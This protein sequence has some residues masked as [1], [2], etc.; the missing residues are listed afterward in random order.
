MYGS[1]SMDH[2]KS[3]I[4]GWAQAEV[5]NGQNYY[6]HGCKMFQH[7]AEIAIFVRWAMTDEWPWWMGKWTSEG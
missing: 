4:S 7:N 5:A 6:N 2:S 3:R 1:L